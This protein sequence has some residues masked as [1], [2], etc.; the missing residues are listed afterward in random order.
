MPTWHSEDYAMQ[1][2][3]LTPLQVVGL[4][5][6]AATLG[7]VVAVKFLPH[8]VAAGIGGSLFALG[9]KLLIVGLAAGR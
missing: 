8:S 2:R 4:C 1:E 5:V 6:L 9:T 3:T 7:A